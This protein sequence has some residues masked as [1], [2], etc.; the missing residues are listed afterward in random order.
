ML[1]VQE[2]LCT[3]YGI[4]LLAPPNMAIKYDLHVTRCEDE[5]KTIITLMDSSDILALS[6]DVH[7]VGNAA[8]NLS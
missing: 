7:S 5:N 8:Q 6:Y 4:Y 2:E 3:L 1:R